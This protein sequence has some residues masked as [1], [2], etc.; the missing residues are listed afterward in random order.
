MFIFDSLCSSLL[1]YIVFYILNRFIILCIYVILRGAAG[2][3]R[4]VRCVIEVF[5][6][7]VLIKAGISSVNPIF[8]AHNRYLD[9][10]YFEV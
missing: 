9:L 7:K 8:S 5:V 6:Y 2:F 4:N 3:K 10:F 1:I